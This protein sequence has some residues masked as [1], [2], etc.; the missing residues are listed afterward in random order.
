[1]LTDA[2]RRPPR[3][4]ITN[5]STGRTVEM[6]FN[7][8]QFQ[9][10][11]GANYEELTVPGLS[12]QPLQFTHTSNEAFSFELFH[13][14]YSRE[15]ME[16]IHLTR[17]FLKSLCFPRGGADDVVG[18]SPPRALLVWPRM[19]SITCVLRKV[20][21]T[22]VLFNRQAQS[23]QFN[24]QIELQEIRD[25]RI[26]SAEVF[27]DNHLRYGLPPDESADEEVA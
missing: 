14:A 20:S 18:G 7:P 5:V 13:I 24:A 9:E 25:F 11:V 8:E 21:L 4:S 22:H 12:H 16:R 1:M 6:Q 15:E 27:E 26:T 10:T 17:R 3:M 23:R 2:M 19:L